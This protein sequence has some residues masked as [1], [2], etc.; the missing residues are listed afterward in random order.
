M[1]ASSSNVAWGGS[2]LCRAASRM[3]TLLLVDLSGDGASD[4]GDY[5]ERSDFLVS[6]TDS[7]GGL[8]DKGE[9]LSE[10]FDLIVLVARLPHSSA[11]AAIRHLN[12]LDAPPCFVVALEGEALERVL[13]LEVGAEDLVGREANAREILTRLHRL[14]ER[15]GERSALTASSMEARADDGAA[16]THRHAQRIL[17]TPSGQKISLTGRDH[18]LLIAFTDKADGLLREGDYPAGHIRTAISRLKRKVLMDAETV[19]PIG[20]VWGQGYRFDAELVRA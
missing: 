10:A 12:R 18:A 4:L 5:L 17:V 13:F 19:L 8:Y 16:W 20:S 15:R 1:L 9:A 2:D 14:M 6:K 11:L 3:R 7:L